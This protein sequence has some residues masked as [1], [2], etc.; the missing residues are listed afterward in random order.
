M[1]LR[2][3]ALF[4]QLDRLA[5]TPLTAD[6][7]V[8][9][10]TAD[11]SLLL[12]L[13]PGA[14]PEIAYW[15]AE[16]E[17]A[18]A[19]SAHEL[20][21]AMRAPHEQDGTPNDLG[22]DGHGLALLGYRDDS[23]QTVRTPMIPLHSTGWTGRPAI[24]GS[25]NGHAWSPRFANVALAID[26][27]AIAAGAT[28][29][30]Y[31]DRPSAT[32]LDITAE[33]RENRLDLRL[34]VELRAS[35][36]VRTRATLTS[37]GD[38]DYILDD[39]SLRLAV[40]DSADECLD[41]TG[42]WA[43]ERVA[44]RA[45]I[46]AGIREKE[47]YRGRPGADAAFL[48]IA[49][50]RGFG[51]GAGEVWGAH[52]AWSGNS[53]QFVEKLSNGAR[54]LGAGELLFPGEVILSRGESY[55]SPW[56]YAGHA[57][58]LDALA[59]RFHTELRS[60]A[61]HPST[62][63][64]VTLNSWE[65]VYFDHSPETMID[66]AERAA[67][68]GV[69]RFVIDDGWFRGRRTERSSLGDWYVDSEVYPEGL[70]PVADAVRALGLQFGLW[71][72]PEMVSPDSDLA[73]QHPEWIL[74]AGEA[75]PPL[76]RHQ[77]VLDLANPA[78]YGYILERLSTL[79]S[80]LG[81]AYL[82]WDH[83]RDLVDAGTDA[84]NAGDCG[85]VPGRIPALHKQTQALYRL[86]DEL[87]QRHPHLEI[88]SCSSGGARVDLG[89]LERTDRVWASDVLD[90]L[91]RNRID[92]WTQQ[93]LP[94]ELV[95]SHIASP[96]SHITGRTHD[97][98]FRA[99]IPLLAHLGI[100]WDLRTASHGELCE[101]AAWVSLHKSLRPLIA[102]GTTV[103]IDNTDASLS[104]SGLVAPDRSEAV[105]VAATIDRATTTPRSR[106][107]LRG[108][109]P[110]AH[111]R[112]RALVPGSVP[113]GLVAPVWFGPD[114][115]GTV[116]PGAALISSGIRLPPLNPEQALVLSVVS[117]SNSD[118]TRAL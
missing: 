107:R 3:A 71:V 47:N 31:T 33:D 98:L 48:T 104:V 12:V 41:F 96:R 42:R 82:K 43:R 21:N 73:R 22:R 80:D 13:G 24:R 14:L 117:E 105:F 39:L 50:E 23:R 28:A 32:T 95:G 116:L 76:E 7:V 63:R 34:V 78:A 54:F 15:G 81:I 100:E 17:L 44:Q 29:S 59:A 68:V 115:K 8:H 83:N 25:R 36:L 75:L 51:Y 110:H 1:S 118:R 108:L 30:A 46:V 5:H 74:R 113:S 11:T 84:A 94:P 77:Q 93:L 89:I 90:P 38:A 55:T 2:R 16:I 9:L 88:E 57:S 109:D 64:P 62:P 61:G 27:D 87:R 114:G 72:E 106:L 18:D 67:A 49:G 101:L 70:E 26:G 6:H 103:R 53:R 97:L 56:L 79:V 4:S 52:L 99:A 92:G 35:G 58:G 86:I 85:G 91:E 69:E 19:A 111:Y 45:P 65:A 66:L 10:H 112:V 20:V 40:A 60:R 102:S 37:T